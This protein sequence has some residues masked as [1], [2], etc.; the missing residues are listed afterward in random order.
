MATVRQLINA[1]VI[2]HFKFS[3]RKKRLQAVMK[4]KQLLIMHVGPLIFSK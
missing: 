3:I 4:M 2:F 1:R